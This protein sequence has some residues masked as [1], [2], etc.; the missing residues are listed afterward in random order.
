MYLKKDGFPKILDLMESEDLALIGA[1]WHPKWF[2]KYR[3][4][5]C[6]HFFLFNTSNINPQSIDFTPTLIETSEGVKR[7]GFVQKIKEFYLMRLFISI[8]ILRFQIGLSQDTG[9]KIYKE[10]I[11]QSKDVINFKLF[12]PVINKGDFNRVEHLRFKIGRHIE[13]LFPEKIS[14]LPKN[15][16]LF[17]YRSRIKDEIKEEVISSGWEE[18]HL[19]K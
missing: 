8:F 13:R 6:V 3:K 19:R 14:F 10:H 18:F 17:S 7:D 4:F 1:P 2:T 15:R 11:L 9:Y 16:S 12:T 5:P